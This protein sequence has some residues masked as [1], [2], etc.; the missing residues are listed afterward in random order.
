MAQEQKIKAAEQQPIA[1]LG[2]FLQTLRDGDN[3]DVL[4]ATTITYLQQ[5]YDYNLIW[6][7]VYDRLN[8]TLIGKDG[9]LPDGDRNFAK[10][11][12]L[13]N[14]GSLL[15]QVVLEQNAVGVADLQAESRAEKWQELA[16]KHGIQ[17]SIVLP[18]GHRENCLG[19]I[20][21][22]SQRWGYLLAGETKAKVMMVIGELGVLLY[23]HEVEWQ[24][25]QSKRPEKSLLRLL[26]S[27]QTLE[28]LEHRLETVVHTTHEFINS[29]RTNIYWFERQDR[30]FWLR[31]SNQPGKV[32]FNQTQPVLGIIKLNELS[33]FYYALAINQVIWVGDNH[34]S[35]KSSFTQQLLH[36]LN[37]K[38]LLAA[39][40]IWQKDL[41]GFL[42]VE[43]H[44]SRNWTQA[45]QSFVKGAAGL[46]SLVSPL[47]AIETSIQRIQADADL[48]SQIAQGIYSDYE[49]DKVLRNCAGRVL[50]RMAATRFLLLQYNQEDNHYKLLYQNQPHNRRQLTFVLEPLKEVDSHLLYRTNTAVSVEN[51]E[52]DL[53]FYNWRSDLLDAGARS[54][55]ISNCHQGH[56][57][58]AILIIVSESQRS[59]SIQEQELLLVIAQQLGVIVRQLQLH[60]QNEQQRAIIHSFQESLKLLGISQSPQNHPEEYYLEQSILK[61]I[62]S[63]LKA[64]LVTLLYWTPGSK[65]ASFASSVITDSKYEIDTSNPVNIATE[66]LVQ[67]AL[68]IDS[69]LSLSIDDIP[70]ES[71]KW[72]TGKDIGQILLFP[73][74][75]T[76]EKKPTGLILIADH[77]QRQWSELSI[78][79]AQVLVS[80]LAW[81]Q[82]WLQVT[83]TL[84]SQTDE[85]QQLNW[86]KHQY[87]SDVQRNVTTL[88]NQIKNT[89]EKEYSDIR[90]QP[91]IRQLDYAN[92]HLTGLLN[93]EQWQLHL[94]SERIPV[95]TLLKRALE[96][97][98]NLLQQ[99]KLWVG[100]HGLGSQAHE[101]TPETRM[102]HRSRYSFLIAGDIIKIELVIY[103]VL[104]AACKRSHV[105]GRI[106]IWCRRLDEGTL[107]I[108]ITDSG[109]I[110]AELLADLNHTQSMISAEYSS[111]PLSLNLIVCQ[112][113]TKKMGGELQ[114][115]QL[116]DNR[117]MSSLLLPL[118][119][120]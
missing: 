72:L 59:W 25:Q 33:D 24:Y 48:T 54:L 55:L 113:L 66:A 81:F 35:L 57:P 75:T 60:H 96:R 39:P 120:Q 44:Q 100:V 80:Q 1:S 84:Q 76:T 92:Y 83:T 61:Q 86:Y 104:L 20:I 106:D 50:E 107:E 5:E 93:N 4:I 17:G 7:A 79:A 34:S 89:P 12:M 109:T 71:K 11:R 112:Q 78:E 30:Y 51:L 16:Q 28:N 3:L 9:I 69:Y 94:N 70:V 21:L 8:H 114:I 110:D 73:V 82:R 64:P 49:L 15:E 119:N 41:L 42:A 87:L 116:Q 58:E 22:G 10:Q 45:E 67:W 47:D 26:E 19:V 40:I 52:E 115:N 85:L 29:S 14:P 18:L 37:A 65:T 77:S 95:A 102:S 38:S 99:Q 117:I 111:Q 46:I 6:I 91:I 13:L 101:R 98:D 97:V 56:K 43:N 31:V 53:R 2:N 62:A 90:H 68:V 103:Q 108:S 23:Q 32:S 105:G 88:L 63:V 118:A 36:C 27:L 74:R